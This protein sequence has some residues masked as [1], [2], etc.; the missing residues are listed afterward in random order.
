VARDACGSRG[1]LGIELDVLIR[2]GEVFPGDEPPL[3]ADI[4]IVGDRVVAVERDLRDATA[5]EVID[6][7]TLM[8][9]PGFI[10]LHSHSALEPFRDPAL[11]PKV[12]QGFTT[13]LI[14][15]DGL[16]PAPVARDRWKERQTY[17]KGLE[18]A[19]PA[20]WTWT[21]FDEYLQA[22][23][24]TRPST[25]LVPSAAHSAIREVVMGLEQRPADDG[26]MRLMQQEAE[27]CFE[28]GARALSFGLIYLPGVFAPT[29]ELVK[30][31]EVAA[32]A[33]APLVPH[34]RNEGEGVLEAAAEMIDVARR[35]GAPLHISHLKVVANPQLVQ[36]LLGLISEARQEID[37][38][39]DQYP[40][41]AGSTVLTALLPPWALEGGAEGILMRLNT[42]DVRQRIAASIHEGVPGW[43][44]LYKACGPDRIFLAHASEPRIA[45][46]GKDLATIAAD[47]GSD[48]VDAVMD[49]L[50]ET[51]LEATMVDHYASED[52][53]L[54]ILQAD[55]ALVGSDG[56][57]G[58]R[59]HPRLYGTAARVLGRYALRQNVI[60]VGEAV[61]RL[62]ARA[63]DR[64]G[65]GDRGRLKKGLRADVVLLHPE[66]FCDRATYESPRQTPS[67][68]E[69]VIIGGE[70]VWLDDQQTGARPGGVY[71][72]PRP[73]R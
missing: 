40:Y 17:L 47:A 26:E 69:R 73:A 9:C 44:N 13:E 6:A 66:S 21:T 34:I 63:A 37:L 18:G 27:K 31:A 8:V 62:T 5:R 49:L 22:L 23:R 45:D 24:A 33:G 51:N 32:R 48:P 30:L 56:I 28:S 59:P 7:S 43:E 1:A 36:P 15:P 57:F 46:I 12:A 50:R 35:S 71:E 29:G 41:G 42:D 70:T 39:F 16:A 20:I 65:L 14:N 2:G 72:S 61:S 67:G 52:V 55:G 4:G 53:I 11:L 3:R 25:T 64:V 58:E 68:M 54:E 38:T 10:D 19:E 60:T